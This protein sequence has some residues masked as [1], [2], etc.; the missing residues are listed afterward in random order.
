MNM[1]KAMELNLRRKEL[2]W[3]EAI[4]DRIDRAVYH[5][6]KRTQIAS[7]FLPLYGPVESGQLT[8][9]SDKIMLGQTNNGQRNL[10]GNKLELP[11]AETTNLIELV[12]E[13]SLTRQ[14]LEREDELGSAVTL[15]TRATNLLCQ[16]CDIVIFSRWTSF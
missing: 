11:E 8:V 13:F 6:C 10:N 3:D 12:V 2:P 15:A 7:K 4:W 9:P 5:E 14:Q 16:A 1:S